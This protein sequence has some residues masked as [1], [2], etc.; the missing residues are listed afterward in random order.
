MESQ[1]TTAHRTARSWMPQ[2]LASRVFLLYGLSILIAALGALGLITYQQFTQHIADNRQSIDKLAEVSTQ[3]ITE[4]ALI[5][6]F[7][8]IRRLLDRI[9][10]AS[11]LREAI[12]TDTAGGRIVA[13]DPTHSGAPGWL[14]DLVASRMPDLRREISVG[15]RN[16][17]V[18]E[19]RYNAD[20]IAG[21]VWALSL[22]TAGLIFFGLGLGLMAMRLALRR[23]LLNL[24]RLSVYEEQVLA[25]AVDAQAALTDDAP[26]EIR[27]AVDVINRTA[28]SL[29]AQFGQRIDSLMHALIQHKKAM[30]E[31]TIVCELDPE[32]RLIYANDRFVSAVGLPRSALLGQRLKDVDG[33]EW[34]PTGSTWHGEVAVVDVTGRRRWHRRSIVPIFTADHQRVE[35]YICIDIDITVQKTSE[36]ELIDQVRRQNMITTFGQRALGGDDVEGLLH[37]ALELVCSGLHVSHAAVVAQSSE[38]EVPFLQAGMG[39]QDGWSGA[40]AAAEGMPPRLALA[41]ELL[42]AHGIRGL[43][44]QQGEAATSGLRFALVAATPEPR[45]FSNADRDFM[46]SLVHVLSAAKERHHAREHLTYLAQFDALTGLPNRRLLLE[47]LELALEAAPAQDTRLCLMYLDLDHF[48]LVN[49]TLGHEAG[50]L[51]LVQ[52]AH[53]MVSCLR[54]GDTVARLSGDEFAVLLT[55]LQGPLDAERVARK[56]ISQLGQPFNLGGREAFISAS[57]GAVLYPEHGLDAPTLVRRADRAM[58]AAKAAGRNEFQFFTEEMSAQASD[59]LAVQT[60]LRAALQREEFFLEYQPKVEL[61]QG[62]ICGFEALLR[63]QHPVRGLVSPG[64]FIPVLEDT[65][66]ILGVGEWVIREVARQI[67]AWQAEG[68]QVPRVALNLSARQFASGELDDQLRAALADT[69]ID[70]SLM[71]FELTE[72]MLMRDP[73]QSTAQLQRFRSYGVRLSVDDFGT[74]YS[75]LSYLSRFPLDALKVDRAFV[76]DLATNPDDA[77]IARA[78]IGLAHSLQLKVVAEGVETTEQLDILAGL[79]CDEIQ[80]FYFSRPVSPEAC[81]R[82]L[83]EGRALERQPDGTWRLPPA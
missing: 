69:G 40:F 21:E 82:L 18:L 39:W 63:W 35:K 16:Y 23:W 64:E 38:D 20:G 61:G 52:A 6:D 1:V 44:V 77:A 25:G 3:P 41:P 17:G 24:D 19:L 62:R 73:A 57:V 13:T 30:D 59:R 55:G 22:Q 46:R 81:A 15:G 37:L 68:L 48:K 65:G 2:S 12:Y 14:V 80:G 32:G 42:A 11:P 70:P 49:D 58:Y 4:S 29:R 50:D 67:L 10:T 5:G 51:L 36:R 83:R 71:E 27:R 45:A 34:R 26:L 78:I 74:G 53:R 31:A 75:S 47:R 72:S 79:G 28:G 66:M 7:D 43:V 60:Q 8:T 33:E 76:N 54:V 9:V 56:L